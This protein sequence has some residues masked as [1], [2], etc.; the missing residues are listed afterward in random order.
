[1]SV[2][3]KNKLLSKLKNKEYR[4]SYCEDYVKSHISF[5]VKVLREQRGLSQKDLAKL[6]GTKQAAISRIEDPEYGKLNISTLLKLSSVFDVSLS[7]K[8]VP[9]SSFLEEYTNSSFNS[10]RCS[11]FNDEIIRLTTWASDSVQEFVPKSK[12]Q[13][14]LY[15]KYETHKKEKFKVKQENDNVSIDNEFLLSQSTI[16]KLDS[17]FKS[18]GVKSLSMNN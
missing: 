2:I 7:V 3:S 6:S 4:D 16:F 8:F 13:S 10:M 15:I 17:R 11:S 12:S 5:Q 18:T 1:M 9:Y 14:I